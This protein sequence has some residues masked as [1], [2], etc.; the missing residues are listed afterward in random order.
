MY[1]RV[2]DTAAFDG[3][4]IEVGNAAFGVLCRL[5][6]WSAG[7]RTD[8]FVPKS[9][10]EMFP[11][12]ELAMLE[13]HGFVQRVVAGELRRVGGRTNRREDVEV[14]MPAA[15]L[16]LVEYLVH[17][18]TASEELVR[19]ERARKGGRA[20]GE[21]RRAHRQDNHKTNRWTNHKFNGKLNGT[22][23]LMTNR[24]VLSGLVQSK[25]RH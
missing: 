17:N 3:R 22:R 13:E 18:V 6:A 14:V 4:V 9:I 19:V 23:N 5:M 2:P 16:W 8:G 15:G 12:R 25:P 24:L 20:S 10:A 7:N 11:K 1:A 21:A